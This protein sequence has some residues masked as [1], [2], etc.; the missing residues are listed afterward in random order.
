MVVGIIVIAVIAV[1]CVVSS[2][3]ICSKAGE[4]DGICKYDYVEDEEEVER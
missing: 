4:K 2:I 3:M 1:I